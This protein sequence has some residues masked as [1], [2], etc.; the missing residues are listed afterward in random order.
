MVSTLVDWNLD[1]IVDEMCFDATQ[2]AKSKACIL[3]EEILIL[4]LPSSFAGT[5]SKSNMSRS[6]GMSFGPELLFSN[7]LRNNGNI[8][9]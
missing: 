5:D 6:M 8:L 4:S 9:I 3:I 2:V 7:N 1:G